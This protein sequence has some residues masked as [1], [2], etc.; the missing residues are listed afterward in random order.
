MSPDLQELKSHP[1]YKPNF[2]WEQHLQTLQCRW[3]RRW[4]MKGPGLKRNN[5]LH[6]FGQK[7][8]P[9]IPGHKM[10]RKCV[11]FN[12]HGAF[13]SNVYFLHVGYKIVYN[14]F[15][16]SKLDTLIQDACQ[17][18]EWHVMPLVFLFVCLCEVFS[19]A[20]LSCTHKLQANLIL[21]ATTKHVSAKW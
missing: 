7:H 9:Y 10:H 11:K 8:D 3:T 17:Y 1:V 6:N 19:Q 12:K 2:T 15:S 13:L 16:Q 5:G 20:L 4:R 14:R 21:W 18:H